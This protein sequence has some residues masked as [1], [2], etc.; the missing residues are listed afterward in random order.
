MVRAARALGVSTLEMPKS[1]SFSRPPSP[2]KMLLP[3]RSLWMMPC[4]RRRVG[5]SI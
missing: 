3:F 1:P 2:Q 4:R 5:Q